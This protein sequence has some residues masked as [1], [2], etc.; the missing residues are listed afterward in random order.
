[1]A[2]DCEN[3]N[4]VN[5]QSPCAVSAANSAACESL[6]SQI[7][8]FQTQFFGTV[9]KTEV[10][11]QVTWSLPCSLDVGL[12]NNP[13]EA[14][15]GL[16]CYF[17][18]LFMD[19]IIGL[20]GPKGDIGSAGTNGRNAYTVTLASFTQPS[21]GAPNVN[22]LT[23]YNPAILDSLYVFIASSG[24]YLVNTADVSGVLFLTLVKEAPG[25]VAGTTVVAGKLVVPSGFP[26][27]S[28]KGDRGFQ[29]PKGDQGDPATNF[30]TTNGIFFANSGTN[31]NT[32]VA[33]A[34]VDFTSS[35]PSILLPAAGRYIVTAVIGVIGITSVALTDKVTF[36]LR[37][38]DISGDVSGSEKGISA[39]I[40]DEEKQVVI[41]VLVDTTGA[42]QT[43]AIFGKCTTADRIA[44]V[45]NATTLTYV[46]LS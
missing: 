39:L 31:Y 26:G 46:R 30:S 44:A 41:N 45:A 34:Q 38:T 21:L 1:M 12:D 3:P 4:L 24:W 2:C 36:K 18:R 19:G 35:V 22:V 32:Q 20:T 40:V 25:A 11:G 23:Q 8:N 5:C 7:Q 43:I 42:N 37:N 17:L 16:A 13:R 14:G 6:P 27:A 29:G 9:V 15:E 10:N 28:V 33:Y